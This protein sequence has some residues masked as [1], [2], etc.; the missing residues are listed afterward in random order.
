MKI[1]SANSY[2][3]G[4]GTIGLIE[5]WFCIW[6]DLANLNNGLALVPKSL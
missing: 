5:S 3:N 6:D 4:F 1:T 2:K